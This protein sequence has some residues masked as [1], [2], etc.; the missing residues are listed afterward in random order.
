[1]KTVVVDT[2]ALVRLYVPDGPLPAG[3]E[4]AVAAAW[5]TEAV[6]LVPELALVEFAQVLRKKE[7]G[8]K[9]TRPECEEILTAMLALPMDV[10]GHRPYIEEAVR[11]ARETN[12]TV[13]DAVF[14][15]L[16]R[17]R[18]ADLVTGDERL[19]AAF[20]AR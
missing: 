7:M 12:L 9:L 6:L 19:D 8:A 16:A 14:L 17:A 18:D 15:A 5:R 10:V 20:G 11:L 13:Y 1:M 3:M 4:E 2:S